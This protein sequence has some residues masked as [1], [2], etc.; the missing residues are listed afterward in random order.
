M[1]CG[2]NSSLGDQIG[3]R[4]EILALDKLA[5]SGARCHGRVLGVQLGL[6]V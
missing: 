6:S 2:P 4:Y 1:E 5:V 3:I